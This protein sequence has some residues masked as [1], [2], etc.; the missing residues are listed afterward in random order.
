MMTDLIGVCVSQSR[1]V[2][3][4]DQQES[5]FPRPIPA[6]GAT[7]P[8]GSNGLSPFQ[9]DGQPHLSADNPFTSILGGMNFDEVSH[10]LRPS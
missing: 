7:L 4:S 9:T 6:Q 2:Q 3:E 5:I 8:S 10:F 1:G